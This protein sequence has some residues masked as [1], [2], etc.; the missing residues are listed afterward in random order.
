M[1]NNYF[2]FKQF[3]INQD[4]CSM[5]VCTD[6]CIFGSWIASL[7]INAGSCLDIGTGTGLLSLMYAQKNVHTNVD[8][9]EIE[10]NAY[11]QAKGNF[12]N[13]SWANRL[14]IFHKDVKNFISEKK[15]DVIISNPP[16]YENDL[17]STEQNKNIAKHNAELSLIELISIV[18]DNLKPEG[19]FAVLLPFHRLAYFENLAKGNSFFI[20]EKLLI[21]QTPKHNYFRVILLFKR[22]KLPFTTNELVIK[23]EEGNYTTEF[24]KL[25]KDY[26]L[27]L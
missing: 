6:A 3:L 26:N 12:E 11:G 16:F 17:L 18:D 21:K 8:A 23:N 9:V 22:T 13:S 5:K 2:Q 10:E 27:H 20:N 25:L 4:K 7:N 1:A 24:K 14:K 19:Y 15:Y